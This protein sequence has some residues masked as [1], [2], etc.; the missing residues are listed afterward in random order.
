MNTG[1]I[2]WNKGVWE[3]PGHRKAVTDIVIAGDWAPIR[4]FRDTILENPEAVYGDVLPELKAGHLRVVN[5]E[6]PLVDE[7]RPVHKSG[8]VLKGESAHI[9]GLTAVPFEV[10]TLGNNH[11]FDYGIDAFRKTMDLLLE[12]GIKSTGAGTTL[13]EAVK[14]ANATVN[15][16]DIGIISFSEGEDLTAA[17]EEKPGVVGWEID[18]IVE[19]I[20]EIRSQVHVIIVVCHGG[21]EYI[22]FPPPYLVDALQRVAAAGADLVIGHHPHVPQGIEICNQV[23][24]CYSLGNFVFYQP[25]DLQYRKIGYLVKAG[26]SQEGLGSVRIIPYEIGSERLKLLKGDKLR[27]AFNLLDTLSE[28]FTRDCGIEDAWNGF[29]K[30]YGVDGFRNEMK[31]IM[32]WFDKERP[33]GAAMFRNRLTTLQHY[34]HLKDFMSRIVEDRLDDAPDWATALVRDFLTRKVDEGLPG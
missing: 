4:G 34:H 12:N 15:G 25:T 1:R 2:D 9:A 26:V 5:L 29:L 30:Y 28:T 14:P 18:Q 16:V 3:H 10:T 11:V 6:C 8:A 32:E 31:I 13:A 17:T 20:R 27:R 24:I 22:P 7:G 33:K 23:P 21:V 19:L